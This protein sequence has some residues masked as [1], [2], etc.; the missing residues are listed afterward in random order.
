MTDDVNNVVP[1]P[2]EAGPIN[3]EG[4]ALEGNENNTPEETSP[5]GNEENK[6][7]VNANN[8]TPENQ[9]NEPDE[10]QPEWFMKDKYKSIDEQA[11]AAFEL[12]KKMGKYWGAPNENYSIEGLEG[13]EES[14]PLIQNL[15]PARS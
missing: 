8:D 11:K 15:A 9:P 10:E 5:D 6:T 4:D 1:T 7:P 3:V 14:D 2:E 13:I 12:Q